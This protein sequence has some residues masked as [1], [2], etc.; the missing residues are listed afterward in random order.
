MHFKKPEV[1]LLCSKGP[2]FG[3][4]YEAVES[5]RHLHV[6]SLYSIFQYCRSSAHGFRNRS[7]HVC[8]N[9]NSVFLMSARLQ[10]VPPISL[11]LNWSLLR[12]RHE[13]PRCVISASSLFFLVGSF[14]FLLST[15]SQT[16]P[17]NFAPQPRWLVPRLSPRRSGFGTRSVRVWFMPHKVVVLQDF[18][19]VTGMGG[20]YG[21][22]ALT[23]MRT[24]VRR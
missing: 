20:K 8:C 13:V 24:C 21:T 4:Y 15:F 23:T 10:L 2:T 6:L 19:G 3:F 14:V 5:F 7:S 17:I 11:A 12:V 16:H 9:Y 1:P 18:C 22:P